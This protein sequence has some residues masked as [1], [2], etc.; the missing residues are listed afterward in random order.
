MNKIMIW[1]QPIDKSWIS[2]E[3]INYMLSLPKT[4]PTVEWVWEEMDRIWDEY[5]LDN[6]KPFL[7]QPIDD[8][9]SHPVWLMNGLFTMLDPVSSY[10]RDAI[11][12]LCQQ[13][14]KN[15]ADYGGGFG[16]LAIKIIEQNPHAKVTIIEPYPS[17]LGLERIRENDQ[18][19]LVAELTAIEYDA[20]IVQD[21]L[22]HVEDPVSLAYIISNSVKVGGKVIFANCFHP[23]IKCHLPG[24][25]HLRHTF[26]YIMKKLGLKY[27][28]KIRGAEHARIF[29]R[30][31][32][33]KLTEAKLA[34]IFSKYYGKLIN[35]VHF[36]SSLFL[37]IIRLRDSSQDVKGRFL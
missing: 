31:E 6:K 36:K 24:T 30:T 8:Y 25:F 4:L 1:G 13:D 26:P 5:N 34:E 12:Y 35:Y 33:L 23:V 28:G 9:Y 14:A 29:E 17:K 37:R 20:I 10:H 3:S 22:E 15:I 16:E 18:I 32:T 2:E 7:N 27:L 19:R 11:S 21:V